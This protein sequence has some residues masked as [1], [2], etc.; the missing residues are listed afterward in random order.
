M[1]NVIEIIDSSLNHNVLL[2]LKGFIPAVLQEPVEIT[3]ENN[4]YE[5][6]TLPYTL[7]L[8]NNNLDH[9]KTFLKQKQQYIKMI[10]EEND[11]FNLLVIYAKIKLNE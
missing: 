4:I 1:N 11:P 9:F 10:N 5:P 3:N 8:I 6:T 7:N 2:F